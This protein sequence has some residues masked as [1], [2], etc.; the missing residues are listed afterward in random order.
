MISDFLFRLYRILG[1]KAI[2]YSNNPRPGSA[3]FVTGD[4]FRSLANHIYDK[5]TPDIDTEKVKER[6]IVFVGDS[7]I[8]KFLKEI[9]P[10]IKNNYI[11]V[12]HNGDEAVDDSLFS[13]TNDKIL[14]W[15]G[16][17]ILVNNPKVIPIPLGIEN[18]HWYHCGIPSIFNWVIKKNLPKVSKIFYGFTVGTN[19]KERAGAL[20]VLKAHP[21]AET[22]PY[23]MNYPMYLKLLSTYKFTLSPPGSS[24]EGHRTWDALYIGTVPIVKESVTINYFKKI[25]VPLLSLSNW[26]ELEKFDSQS[27]DRT[28]DE[29][30]KNSKKETLYMSYWADKI[31]TL[32]D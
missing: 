11:L 14:K 1:R 16:I 2:K 15:Y 24:V 21:L 10:L 8:R 4:G 20:E 7:I 19:A 22:L 29:I 5:L 3:E 23:W 6:D 31:R 28:F 26:K 25:G 32:K 17:N 12:T 18:K 9:H 27:L 13:L 30:H